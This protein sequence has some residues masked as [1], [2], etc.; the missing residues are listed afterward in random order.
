MYNRGLTNDEV[1]RNYMMA[2]ATKIDKINRFA[3]NDVLD[4]NKLVSYEKAR[5][6]FNCLLITG[7]ISPYKKSTKTP[8]G[9]TLTK[10]DLE[11]FTYTTEFNLLDKKANGTYYSSNNVQGTSSQTYP[12][13]NLKVYLAKEEITT[14][15][16]SGE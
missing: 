7:E 9:V 14:D 8:S 16:D 10:P 4:N 12:I 11:N 3:A 15:P 2:P 6:K 1:L 13:H 5:N